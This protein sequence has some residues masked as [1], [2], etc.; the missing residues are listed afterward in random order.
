MATI[1]VSDQLLQPIFAAV[2]PNLTTLFF[3]ISPKPL[4]AMVTYVGIAG[5]LVPLFGLRPL[6]TGGESMLVNW[7]VPNVPKT[8]AVIL[9]VCSPCPPTGEATVCKPWLGLT[10]A[11]LTSPESQKNSV[12]HTGILFSAS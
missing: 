8:I 2:S 9:T 7:P 12:T 4:P 10:M 5:L 6:I 1:S 11:I 3:C